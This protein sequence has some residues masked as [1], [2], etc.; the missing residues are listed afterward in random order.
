MFPKSHLIMFFGMFVISFLTM[1]FV[2]I[3]SPSDWRPSVNQAYAAI[4]MGATMV[5]LEAFMHPMPKYA[6]FITI[7]IIIASIYAIRNQIGVSS[8]EYL[9]DMIPHHSMAVLTSKAQIKNR[10]NMQIAN[11][12]ETIYN[13]QKDEIRYMKKILGTWA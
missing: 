2:M 11:L 8:R 1:P 5:I 7:S 9:H 3:N 12:A 10:E 6:W 13:N 4:F